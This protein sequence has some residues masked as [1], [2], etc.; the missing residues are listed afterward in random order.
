VSVFQP[1]EIKLHLREAAEAVELQ[2]DEVVL[3]EDQFVS[4]N[5]LRLHYLDW[6]NADKPPILFLHG[7]GLTAHTWDLVCLALRSDFHCRAM[8]LRGHGDSDWSP[9]VEYSFEAH[10]GD[11]NALVQHLGLD[12]FILVG[13]SLG[14]GVSLGWA[15]QHVEKLRALVLVDTGPETRAA[16]GRR[17]ADFVAGPSEL[18][19]IEDFVQRA[20]EFNPLRKPE[21]LRRSLH[22]NLRQTATGKWT[23]KHDHRYGTTATEDR[24]QRS[25][26]LWEAVGKITCPTLV[27]RGGNS[28]V[29]HDEDAEKLASHLPRGSWVRIDGAG[30][31]VQGDQ[32][33]LLVEALRRF[34]KNEVGLG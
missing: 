34:F 14:G 7:R 1:E 28:D 30:H 13:M 4:A 11:L 32:P 23:W 24:Q 8:D 27:V 29:I 26:S 15:G 31:T 33:K 16:G 18:D 2:L 6:G 25:A 17:V 19:S 22:H 10:R 21:L 12:N 5:G 3:P 20:M 9:E